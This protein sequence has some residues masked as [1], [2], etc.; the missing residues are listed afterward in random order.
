LGFGYFLISTLTTP[1]AQSGAS[2]AA[3]E[4]ADGMPHLFTAG[5]GSV[6]AS[7]ATPLFS[8][9]ATRHVTLPHCGFVTVSEPE[10]LPSF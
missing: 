8:W 10:I 3:I 6:A 4:A 5:V 1:V 7:A 2:V 9:P